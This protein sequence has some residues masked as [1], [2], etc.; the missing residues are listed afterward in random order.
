MYRRA[1]K[2][3][4]T[5]KERNARNVLMLGIQ[6]NKAYYFD[7]CCS[8]KKK[9]QGGDGSGLWMP[10]RVPGGDMRC[11][12]ARRSHRSNIFRGVRAS[13]S[14]IVFCSKCVGHTLGGER[15][16]HAKLAFK[17]QVVACPSCAESG[18][19]SSHIGCTRTGLIADIRQLVGTRRVSC[20][21]SWEGAT[22][23]V[24]R[25]PTEGRHALPLSSRTLWNIVA[26]R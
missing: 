23:R 20:R 16:L 9:T 24:P 4:E 11:A 2:R 7:N 3:R 5:H 26:L 6:T 21:T 13:G 12:G 19:A 22:S 1:S 17:F 18:R 25:Y 14:R 10:G 15:A 8:K